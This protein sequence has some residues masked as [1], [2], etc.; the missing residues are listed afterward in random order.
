MR[1]I[2]TLILSAIM[3]YA[4][5]CDVCG[6]SVG[7]FSSGLLNLGN[8]NFIGLSYKTARFESQ[9]P[10]LFE[11]EQHIISN[12]Q[13]HTTELSGRWMPSKHIQIMASI[14]FHVMN[15]VE[16]GATENNYGIGDANLQVQWVFNNT[17]D[18]TSP[19][20]I[21]R[22]ALGGGIKMPTGKSDVKSDLYDL[23]IPNMQLG[24]GSWDFLMNINGL[25]RTQ[26][27]GLLAEFG[28]N[29]NSANTYDYKF[30]NRMQSKILLSRWVSLNPEGS[31]ILR[32]ELG[33]RHTYSKYDFTSFS[34]RI[35]N[36][37]SHG[38]FFDALCGAQLLI[39]NWSFSA[40]TQLPIK[41]HFADGYVS[42]KWGMVA[43]IHFIIPS[44]KQS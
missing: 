41:Q 35:T 18:T 8:S 10:T 30:G 2:I 32:P 28:Y 3:T 26:S 21:Y 20:V 33:V 34:E 11:N 12:E 19:K 40:S 6:C 13:F 5:A 44:K 22:L 29:L 16:A 17:S 7:S 43:Q 25:I 9:H 31:R 37:F 42:Q 36:D 14:P 24:S 1:F 23:I 38:Y 4:N 39:N 15:R 27:W